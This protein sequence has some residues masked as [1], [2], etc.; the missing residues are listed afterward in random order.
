M[1]KYIKFFFQM[2]CVVSLITAWALA[3]F[4]VMTFVITSVINDFE[5]HVGIPLFI[6]FVVLYFSLLATCFK[7]LHVYMN[8]KKEEKLLSLQIK[9]RK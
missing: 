2:T 6:A 3:N 5:P 8:R 4:F 9:T 7:M 1:K